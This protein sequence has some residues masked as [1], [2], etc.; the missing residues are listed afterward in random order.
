MFLSAVVTWFNALDHIQITDIFYVPPDFANKRIYSWLTGMKACTLLKCTTH[1]T[2]CRRAG[3]C[4]IGLFARWAAGSGPLKGWVPSLNTAWEMPARP[5][6]TNGQRNMN[7]LSWEKQSNKKSTDPYEK[8]ANN[9]RSTE[10]YECLLPGVLNRWSV[11]W[12]CCSLNWSMFEDCAI[13]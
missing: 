11:I 12:K 9:Q 7:L 4:G 8:N 13:Y 2:I 6:V 3:C 1:V 10:M 5:R